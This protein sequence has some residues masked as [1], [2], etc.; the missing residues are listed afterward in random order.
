MSNEPLVTSIKSF[1]VVTLRFFLGLT[2]LRPVGFLVLP[3]MSWEMVM[4]L[5]SL[6]DGIR[7]AGERGILDLTSVELLP[8]PLMGVFNLGILE[9]DGECR[10][11]REVDFR[12]DDGDFG[13]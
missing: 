1:S 12:N 2:G 9:G 3:S 5:L 4:S 11:S 13:I 10:E 7:L 8:F 6:S